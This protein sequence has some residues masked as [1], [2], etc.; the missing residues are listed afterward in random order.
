MRDT[1][2]TVDLSAL[3]HNLRHVRHL[4]P[5][6]KVLAMVKADAYGHGATACLQGVAEA[7]ALGVASLAEA[8]AL[9]Q[10]GWQ[11][12]VVLVEGVFSPAEWAA[13]QPYNI[14][15]VI[16]QHAQLAWF[17]QNP[18]HKPIWLKLNS[19]M[20]RLGFSADNIL[21]IATQIFNHGNTI[22]LTS[23][24]ANAD[25]QAH[26]LNQ[27]QCQIFASV[28]QQLKTQVSPT[29]QGSL[30]NSAGIVNFPD[31]HFDWVRPG[32]MLYGASPVLHASAK[33]LGL[34][35]VMRFAAQIFAIHTLP[36]GECVGYGSG[37]ATKKP[38]RIGIVS[39]GYGDGYPRMI[40]E[41]GYVTGSQGEKLPII[42][43]VAMDML[44]VDITD[45]PH[46]D[47]YEKVQLW[48]NCPTVEEVA[49]WN[50]SISYEVLCQ[51]TQRPFRH[52]IPLA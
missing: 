13:I 51:T 42:G 19:G 24:F 38:A 14:E 9:I 37:W 27:A 44:V 18:N 5:N 20:N 41:A 10:A 33:E 29:I 15:C 11:K 46:I 36:I 7:D 48:G 31:C 28:L 3:A 39:V 34:R 26:P 2:I 17:L 52:Y 35:P 16:H 47:L 30:C 22:I 45:F 8:M 6:S 1:T 21:P 40:S 23:H 43:R 49:S 50:G 12:P 4:A 25:N 32:I